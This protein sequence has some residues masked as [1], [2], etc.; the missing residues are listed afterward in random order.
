MACNPEEI[1]LYV[2]G[3]LGPEAAARVRTHTAAC[4]AC[5]ELLVTEQA[6]ASALGGLA[7]LE[8]PS[9]FCSETVRRAE[10]DVTH[11]FRSRG[12][13]RRAAVVTASLAGLSLLLLWPTGVLG[14]SAQALGPLRCMGRFALGWI[15][16]SALSVFIIARTVSRSLL[17]EMSLP[18]G[19][20]LVV[21]ALLVALLAWLIAGYRKHATPGAHGVVR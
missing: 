14:A 3:E 19:V 21:L 2:E 10:C 4:A 13:R 20:A 9:N 11:A 6:L 12:E 16:S 5:R 7:D 15:E 8:P 1:L 17:H 18:T